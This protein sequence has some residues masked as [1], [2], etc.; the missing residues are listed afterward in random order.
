MTNETLLIAFVG[1][2][3]FA[4]VVQAIVLLAFFFFA[5][6][7][8]EK[9]RQDFEELRE[10]ALPF[11]NLSRETFTRIAPHIEPIT[12]DFVTSIAS[13]RAISADV[14][15]ITAKVR[16]QVDGAQ[17]ST[18]EIVDKVKHQ[19]DRMDAMLTGMLDV[20]DRAGAFLQS[21][22]GTPARQLAGV[23]NAAKAIVDS[24]RGPGSDTRRAA[25]ANDNETNET[26]V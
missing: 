12:T 25:A 20:I 14:A 19:A 9:M 2:T 4:L 6:K 5:K 1:L 24:L 18:A 10:S 7:S 11:L 15:D 21:A 17:A 13:M 23:L 16:A 26:F 22:V 3:G 8:Y